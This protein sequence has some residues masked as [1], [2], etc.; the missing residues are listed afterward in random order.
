MCIIDFSIKLKKGA[1]WASGN[2]KSKKRFTCNYCGKRKRGTYRWVDGGKSCE[3][4][5]KLYD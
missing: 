4:C 2:I 1:K 3:V 5:N